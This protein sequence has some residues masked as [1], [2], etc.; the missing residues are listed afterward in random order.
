MK[1]KS[2][3]RKEYKSKRANLT[4]DARRQYAIDISKQLISKWKFQD[5]TIS[6]FMPIRRLLEIDTSFIVKELEQ[7]NR[8]CAPVANLVSH[9]M[10]NYTFSED[11]LIENQWGIPEPQNGILVEPKNIDVV[12]VPLLISDI[13]G[14]RL[15][16]GKGFYDR[17]LARCRRDAL[18][19]GV[20]YFDPI[21]KTL[22]IDEHDLP[23]NYL[24]T[25][26]TV[27]QSE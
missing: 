9:E 11:T 12:I 4:E 18:F 16:Y 22:E 8:L 1:S 15:G 20:N 21:S 27:Y 2:T 23:L 3:L 19:I 5:K 10:N 7:K 13:F 17:F 14:N 24:V 6:V 26:S 25:P